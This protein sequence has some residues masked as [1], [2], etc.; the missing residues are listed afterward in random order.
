MKACY[1][2]RG[3]Q[4]EIPLKPETAEMLREFFA[5]KLPG[6]RPF[7]AANENRMAKM[8]YAD[9]EA[10]GIEPVDSA[11][12]VADFHALRQTTGSL[13]AAGGVH[14]KVAQTIMRHSTVDMTMTRYSHVYQGQE[15]EAIEKLPDLTLPSRE[16]QERA[17]I[18]RHGRAGDYWPEATENYC[19]IPCQILRRTTDSG[20]L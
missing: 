15:S 12:R 9:L 5:D 2:K 1:S 4:D 16:Q 19:Q 10:A 17:K 13:L 11:G 3:R 6:V 20:G 14:P 18:D 7:A 8:L